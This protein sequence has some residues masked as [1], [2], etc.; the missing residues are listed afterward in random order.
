[1][2][3]VI[4]ASCNKDSTD[5]KQHINAIKLVKEAARQIIHQITSSSSKSFWK[6]WRYIDLNKF[7]FTCA[8]HNSLPLTYFFTIQT[9]RKCTELKAARF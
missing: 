5:S 7:S 8:H 2:P 1:M 3:S 4:K 9:L 6:V